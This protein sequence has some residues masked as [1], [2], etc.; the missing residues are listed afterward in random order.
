M[1]TDTAILVFE[2][3]LW[4]IAYIAYRMMMVSGETK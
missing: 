3:F 1:T 2:I 4:G